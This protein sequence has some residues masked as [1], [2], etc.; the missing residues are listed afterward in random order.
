MIFLPHDTSEIECQECAINHKPYDKESDFQNLIE[1]DESWNTQQSKNTGQVEILKEETFPK[2]NSQIVIKEPALAD[3][4]SNSSQ[5]ETQH[6]IMELETSYKVILN[7]SNSLY[8]TLSNSA[9][10]ESVRENWEPNASSKPT[11]I[12]TY[13]LSS[14]MP[15]CSRTDIQHENT[16]P[17]PS[18]RK[19]SINGSHVLSSPNSNYSRDKIQFNNVE[20]KKC[21]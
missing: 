17:I 6:E 8:S 14:T 13:V 3:T 18:P 19:R 7:D 11:I 10:A 12:D 21:I 2:Q 9:S 20:S 16:W 5:A 15:N 4:L 1:T